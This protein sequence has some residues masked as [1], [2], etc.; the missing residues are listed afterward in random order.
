MF[1]KGDKYLYCAKWV[2]IVFHI[3]AVVALI[4]GAILCFNNSDI[5][6]G[7]IVLI[8][9]GAAVAIS[10]IFSFLFLSYLWDVKRIRNKLY[11]E[12]DIKLNRFFDD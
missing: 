12:N 7:C 4:T 1:R 10:W 9:G 6:R 11:E 2:V 3:V 8:S 5:L